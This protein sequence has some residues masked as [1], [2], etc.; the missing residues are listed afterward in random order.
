MV[1]S[2]SADVRI[3]GCRKRVRAMVKDRVEIRVRDNVRVRVR[4][5][6]E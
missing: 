2:V 1:E 6:N 5:L 3:Y 4:C